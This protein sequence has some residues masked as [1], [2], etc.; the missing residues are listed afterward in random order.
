M[1]DPVPSDPSV[2]VVPIVPTVPSSGTVPPPI[3][4]PTG[5]PGPIAQPTGL[6]QAPPGM[7]MIDL[8]ITV[9]RE[10]DNFAV[11]DL[12]QDVPLPIDDTPQIPSYNNVNSRRYTPNMTKHFYNRTKHM[13]SLDHVAGLNTHR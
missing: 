7:P 5:I 3:S 1:P 9:P 8:K 2:P 12:G 4:V 13:A 11:P 6:P 10:N